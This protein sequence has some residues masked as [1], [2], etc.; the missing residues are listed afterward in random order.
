MKCLIGI[1]CVSYVVC[2][3]VD[4]YMPIC[5]VYVC[6]FVCERGECIYV[7]IV[8]IYVYVCAYICKY[9]Y[10]VSLCVCVY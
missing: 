3:Y 8:D 9:I 1:L 7:H 10:C 4:M 2:I 6:V 5:M